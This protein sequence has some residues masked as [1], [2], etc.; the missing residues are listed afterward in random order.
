MFGD[1]FFNDLLDGEDDDEQTL[2]DFGDEDDIDEDL[3]VEEEEEIDRVR[4]SKYNL[5]DPQ[6]APEFIYTYAMNNGDEQHDVD[7]SIVSRPVATTF[8]IE[9]AISNTI[10][11][12]AGLINELEPNE[13]IVKIGCNYG[14]KVWE[15]YTEPVHVRKSNRG[16][17]KIVKTKKRKI[18]GTGRYFNSQI[19]L[20]ARD[21]V[22]IASCATAKLDNEIL[23]K[24]KIFRNGDIQL[25]GAKPDY[26]NHVVRHINAIALLLEKTSSR[27]DPD[28]EVEVSRLSAA[29]LNYKFTVIMP[30][31][32]LISLHE[33]N[34]IMKPD[35]GALHLDPRIIDI[36]YTGEET[37]LSIYFRTPTPKKRFKNTLVNIFMK[38]KINILGAYDEDDVTMIQKYLHDIFSQNYDTLIKKEYEYVPRAI[39]D[40]VDEE[41]L[42]DY[43]PWPRDYIY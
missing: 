15:G 23:Y 11:H 32:M 2:S 10:F 3:P 1:S 22:D 16:R 14:E 5:L 29:M 38:G 17:K 9:G 25:P 12:E 37:K 43:E 24:Y 13:T 39:C 19:T 35:V 18:Q 20:I 7:Y 31:K 34:R 6:N 21:T 28:K 30:P 41:A 36:K 26:I 8:T 33:L 42:R 27:V 4:T 40:N